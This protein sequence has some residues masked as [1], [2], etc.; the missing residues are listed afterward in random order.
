MSYIVCFWDKSK[1]QVSDEVGEKLQIAKISN[2]VKDFYLDKGLYSFSGIDKII[3]KYDAFDIFPS[4]FEFLKS[5]EDK[6]SNLLKLEKP[7]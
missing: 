5:M 1:L 6:T 4:E 2:E 3:P 7:Q